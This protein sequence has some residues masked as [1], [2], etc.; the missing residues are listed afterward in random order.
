VSEEY[1]KLVSDEV[2]AIKMLFKG[3]HGPSDLFNWCRWM[4]L[5]CA[6]DCGE[7]LSSCAPDCR[8][9]QTITP[10]EAMKHLDNVER[11]HVVC[12]D[13][14]LHRIEQL[15]AEK[16]ELVEALKGICCHEYYQDCDGCPYSKDNRC[17]DG[18]GPYDI[19]TSLLARLEGEVED[20]NG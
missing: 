12:L 1:K 16:A 18:F 3:G 4:R 5:G 14:Q 19:A 7:H 8:D 10:Y 13:G 6:F 11:K 17:D 9:F 15:E 20:G 2:E